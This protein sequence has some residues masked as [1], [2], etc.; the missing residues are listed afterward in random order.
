MFKMIF[1]LSTLFFLSCGKPPADPDPSFKPLVTYNVPS[2][3]Y[4][5]YK[6]SFDWVT[7]D[8]VSKT[9][10]RLVRFVPNDK[11]PKYT[12]TWEPYVNYLNTGEA[13][14]LIKDDKTQF[15][16][17]SD[18]AAGVAYVGSPSKPTGIIVLNFSISMAWT[19]S[20]F[21][22]VV[23]HEVLHCLGFNHTFDTDYSIMNYDYVYKVSGVTNVDTDRLAT[24]FPFSLEVVTT[25]DLEKFAAFNEREESEKYAFHLMENYGL[26]ENRAQSISK[27]LIS[28]KKLN[29]MRALTSKEKDLLSNQILGFGFEKGK[30]ALENYMQGEKESMDDLIVVAASK[31][32]TSPEHI[33]ELF[34]EIFLK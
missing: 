9:G 29:G 2:A 17:V 7:A 6:S 5:K 26:S 13:W 32:E 28:Y 24:A 31:N 10:K 8:I 11:D 20:N 33:K 19:N 21:R 14:V 34:G 23:D 3:V 30:K 22:Q 18:D 12:G 1:L 27:T 16:G 25:K 15:T 4:N